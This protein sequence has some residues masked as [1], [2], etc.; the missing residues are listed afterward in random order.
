MKKIFL[1]L[2]LLFVI[3]N[4]SFAEYKPIPKNLS[5]QYKKKI[6]HITYDNLN[7]IDV[8]INMKIRD[9]DNYNPIPQEL[10][11]EYVKK[12]PKNLIENYCID[13]NN[14]LKHIL[15]GKITY[16]HQTLKQM[17]LD[18]NENSDLIYQKYLNDPKNYEQNKIF[19]EQLKNMSGLI[20]LYPD[21]II[22]QIQPYI[23]KYDLG[24]EPG[25]E[26]D[27]FLYKYYIE[28]YPIKYSNE[29]KELLKLKEYVYTKINIYILKISNKL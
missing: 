24:I 6:E 9:F 21:T 16:N 7:G 8:E 13:M 26:N 22:E 10:Q 12:I 27:I 19:I 2:F 3:C 1:V 28:K 14:G 5:K 17:L 11:N 15:Y 29:L 25:S 18:F 4:S 23:V 20:S